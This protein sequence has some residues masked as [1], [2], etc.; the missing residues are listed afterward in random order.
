MRLQLPDQQLRPARR[1]PAG[2]GALAALAVAAPWPWFGAWA[3]LALIP[4]LPAVLLAL[5]YQR[6]S[7]IRV[8][9]A[10][11][12]AWCL[13]GPARRRLGSVALDPAEIAELRLEAGLPSRLLGLP[14]LH[15]LTRDGR[16]HRFRF[17]P[18]A[19][20]LAEALH[21]VLQQAARR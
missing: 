9:Q 12:I 3:L 14:E 6:G 7:W 4:G 18:G 15:L 20:P 19:A 2:A 11:G 16:A 1:L 10:R 17:F 8:S 5:R 13:E 21:T